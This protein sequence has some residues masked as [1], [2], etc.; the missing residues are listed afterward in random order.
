MP[1]IQLMKFLF[2]TRFTPIVT[3]GLL[4]QARG[5]LRA[6]RSPP[7][8]ATST[9]ANLVLRDIQERRRIPMSHQE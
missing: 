1:R 8:R 2:A 9:I 5:L 7:P 6:R 4:P 3:P